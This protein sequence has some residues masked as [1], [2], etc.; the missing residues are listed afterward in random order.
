VSQPVVVRR[1]D[2][3]VHEMDGPARWRVAVAGMLLALKSDCHGLLV[4]GDGP[5][6]R[7]IIIDVEERRQTAPR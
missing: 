5:H 3:A 2:A 7:D 6:T 1:D 4:I